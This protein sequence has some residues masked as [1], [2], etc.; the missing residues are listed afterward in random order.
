MIRLQHKIWTRIILVIGITLLLGAC[1]GRPKG[2]VNQTDMINVLTDLHKLDGSLNAKGLLYDQSNKKNDYYVS[3]LRKYGITQA[4]FDSSLVWYSKDPKKFDRIYEK[5]LTQLTD[6]QTD[7]NKGKYHP[8]DSTELAKIKY[9][10]WN[11][12][13]KYAL[14]KDSARTHLDFEIPDQNFMLGDIYILKFLQRIA[15][16]DSCKKQL[17]RFQINYV[18]GRV[19]GVIKTAYNDGLTRRYN[20]RISSI[21]PSK[22]KSIS[23]ELLGS[24]V[25]KGKLNTTTDS[26]SLTRVY[27]ALKQDSLLKVLQKEDPSHY[28][29]FT[30]RVIPEL[31]QTEHQN[32]RL[33]ILKK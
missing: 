10:I 13:I 21:H 23:G 2:V 17:I 6:L 30:P 15:P 22:I 12:R 25:Y 7:I 3:V 9:N 29:V 31:I 16:E 33:L 8:V 11:K 19:R 26:I 20:L 27:N 1:D 18:N 4:E 5:V 24:S 14:T 32:I 28:P